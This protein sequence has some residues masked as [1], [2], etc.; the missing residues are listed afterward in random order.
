MKAKKKALITDITNSVEAKI[1]EAGEVSKKVKKVIEK[2][3][4]KLATKLVKVYHKEEK[5]KEKAQKKTTGKAPKVK[6]VA[7]KLP[8]APA[9]T[10]IQTETVSE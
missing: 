1:S 3:A 6:K 10:A 8:V 9:P 2:S 5:K 4:E 7:V